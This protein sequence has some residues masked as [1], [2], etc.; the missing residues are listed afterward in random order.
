MRTVCLS[1]LAVL[2]IGASSISAFSADLP[3]IKQRG[4]LI[5]ATSGDLVPVTYLN[6]L[7]GAAD[8]INI[9]RFPGGD[10]RDVREFCCL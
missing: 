3:E 6:A 1:A 9:R 2:A 8:W 5:A 4:K 7:C 10:C